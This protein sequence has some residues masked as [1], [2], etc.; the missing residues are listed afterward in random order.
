MLNLAGS[1][2]LD[3]DS[4]QYRPPERLP[5]PECTMP[6]DENL[7]VAYE[8]E[9]KEDCKRD[10]RKCSPSKAT[11]HYLADDPCSQ[12]TR[13]GDL[14]RPGIYHGCI[15]AAREFSLFLVW[16]ARCWHERMTHSVFL[17][18]DAARYLSFSGDFRTLPTLKS[19]KVTDAVKGFLRS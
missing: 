11:V 15:S 19:R 6:Y 12:S 7:N 2:P 9:A 13:P 18:T 4:M 1:I 10:R 14:R 8:P 3:L 17:H 5:V 16:L